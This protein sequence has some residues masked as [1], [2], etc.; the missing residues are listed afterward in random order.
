[1]ISMTECAGDGN[2]N[3]AV[4][5]VNAIV[6]S[7]TT[8]FFSR[9]LAIALNPKKP[10]ITGSLVLYGLH[11]WQKKYV[12]S[13]A[14]LPMV[15]GK[16][17]CF[18]SLK[19]LQADYPWLTEEAIRLALGRAEK[20]LKGHFVL[21][22]NNPE[23]ERGKLHFWLSPE[24]IRKY[25][26]N[27]EKKKGFLALNVADAC[28]YGVLEAI[29]I[30]N[31]EYV[32]ATEHNKSPV[33]DEDDRIYRQLSPTIL[34][35]PRADMN[36]D[37]KSIL[38]YSR[39]AVSQAL[40]NLKGCGKLI[41]QPS[42]GGF[43]R[44]KTEGEAVTRVADAV[45]KV[46]GRVTK[47]AGAVT[48]V[49]GRNE[50]IALEPSVYAGFR[51]FVESSYTNTHT[52]AVTNTDSKCLLP[53][54]APLRS[55]V[56]GVGSDLSPGGTKLM[57]IIGHNIELMRQKEK[58]GSPARTI[59][60]DGDE[61]CEACSF[62]YVNSDLPMA[63]SHLPEHELPY[64]YVAMD[65][66]T[67]K[68]Y[69]RKAEIKYT[70][71]DV[72]LLCDINAFPYTEKDL[73]GLRLVLEMNPHLHMEHLQ[74]LFKSLHDHDGI[75]KIK[76]PR[77]GHDFHYFARRLRTLKDFLH[78]LPQLVKEYFVRQYYLYEVHEP[79]IDLDEVGR[80]IF[81][82]ADMEEPYFSLAFRGDT[83]TAIRY[84][85]EG[86]YY[87]DPE[88]PVYYA[89]CVGLPTTEKALYERNPTMTTS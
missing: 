7:D 9:E 48:K 8:L 43:Y 71:G 54:T 27:A 3:P 52:N 5:A 34:T 20:K 89:E 51:A 65:P 76:A 16:R 18:R 69:N 74:E 14:Y 31:L 47:V 39:K 73:K 53:L 63:H 49:A 2:A 85:S 61:F 1:M 84:V 36:G 11:L 88:R 38:P 72:K 35:K 25:K 6:G 33:K 87:G 21:D 79:Y 83:T 4:K 46:A 26:F 45:T 67:G 77:I 17:G 24:L 12:P 44:L 78:Y 81:S 29:L 22:R 57:E 55:S 82:Y 80:P 28:R 58:L 32:T 41:E 23:A 66:V 10:D 40:S 42:R 60:Y 70:L 68:P 62:D 13:F 59:I 56:T 15:N 30:S 50:V 64:D 86:P 75:M 19:E 37:L